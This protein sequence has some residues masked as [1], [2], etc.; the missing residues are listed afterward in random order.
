[1]TFLSGLPIGMDGDPTLLEKNVVEES[2]PKT[3][4]HETFA[5]G[6]SLRVRH[7][8]GERRRL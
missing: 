5:P 4:H 6:D 1:M 8:L 7:Y 2:D 3:R